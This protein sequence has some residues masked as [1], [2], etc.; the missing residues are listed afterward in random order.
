MFHVR[1]PCDG[2]PL[3]VYCPPVKEQAHAET[4][5][6]ATVVSMQKQLGLSF[7]T[8]ELL[9]E[10]LTHTSYLNERPLDVA[11]DNQ[12]LEFLGDA[13][14]DLLVAEELY[15]HYPLAREGQLTAMRAAV[16]RTDSVAR[17]SHHIRLS[18]HL[19]LGHGEEATGG[20]ARRPILCAALEAVI[21]AVF[22]DQGMDAARTLVREIFCDAFAAL[23]LPEATRDPKSLL[24]ERV[25][26]EMHRTPIYCSLSESGPD[27]AKEFLVEVRVGDA[28]LGYGRGHSKQAAEQA[29][30]RSALQSW[31]TMFAQQP[32]CQS[33][34]QGDAT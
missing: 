9:R 27:H 8:P 18:E 4:P 31:T 10:A 7:R 13:V 26:A 28:V 15:H 6:E 19:L 5:P 25:Q 16:V 20:R 23:D 3:V 2:R 32:P 1:F 24:Q 11:S 22:L 12:R 30:A 21:G 29:A 14:L 34:S 17:A 33:T